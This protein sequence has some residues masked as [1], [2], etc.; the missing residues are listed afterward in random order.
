MVGYECMYCNGTGRE[1]VTIIRKGEVK[2][3]KED[4]IYCYG[5]GSFTNGK[6]DVDFGEWTTKDD[7]RIYRR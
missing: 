1:V 2:T 4:C 6:P 5:S 3:I 7:Y